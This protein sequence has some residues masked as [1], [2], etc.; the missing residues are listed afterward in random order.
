[1]RDGDGRAESSQGPL[2]F[3]I[4]TWHFLLAVILTAASPLLLDFKKKHFKRAK[5]TVTSSHVAVYVLHF[6]TPLLHI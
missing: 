1:M 3:S 2:M 6:N 4:S 5:L